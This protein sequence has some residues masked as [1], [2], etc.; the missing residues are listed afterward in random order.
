MKHILKFNKL[1]ENINLKYDSLGNITNIKEIKDYLISEI[2]SIS[3]I[4]CFN[5]AIQDITNSY[6]NEI[7]HHRCRDDALFQYL[8]SWLTQTTYN[9]LRSLKIM[10]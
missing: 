9:A 4:Q 6:I 10:H 1:N 5:L 8:F 2:K 3:N 7:T